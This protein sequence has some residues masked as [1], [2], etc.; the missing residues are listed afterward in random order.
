[1]FRVDKLTK[2]R[3]RS[4]S[5]T[6]G[7]GGGDDASA[8]AGSS[9]SA[10]FAGTSQAGKRWAR[11]PAWLSSSRSSVAW[12]F[13]SGLSQGG[14]QAVDVGTRPFFRD[15]DAYAVGQLGIPAAKRQAGM[16]AVF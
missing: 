2:C 16:V 5:P 15:G 7:N 9:D 3:I 10:S 4:I 6:S 12:F 13:I 1:M 14:G 11:R 8:E